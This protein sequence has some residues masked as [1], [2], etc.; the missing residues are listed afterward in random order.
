[1]FDTADR[2]KSHT[3]VFTT[4]IGRLW[5]KAGHR[6]PAPPRG[7]VTVYGKRVFKRTR[8]FQFFLVYQE[9]EVT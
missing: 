1:M 2:L 5:F 8:V 9:Q 6:A 4:L 7:H 3:L